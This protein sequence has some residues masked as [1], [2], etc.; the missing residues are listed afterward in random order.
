LSSLT[1]VLNGR[2]KRHHSIDD[3][4]PG[5]SS[6]TTD[7]EKIPVEFYPDLV[8]ADHRVPLNEQ[9]MTFEKSLFSSELVVRRINESNKIPMF[10]LESG[11]MV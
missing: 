2:F 5:I 6:L 8:S 3:D 1:S 9:Q 4:Y 10:S 7:E 11:G